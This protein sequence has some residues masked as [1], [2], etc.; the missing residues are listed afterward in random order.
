MRS[1]SQTVGS[2]LRQ[3]AVLP[4]GKCLEGAP[5]FIRVLHV[6]AC[7]GAIAIAGNGATTVRSETGFFVGRHPRSAHQLSAQRRGAP[8]GRRRLERRSVSSRCQRPLQGRN[9]IDRLFEE[10]GACGGRIFFASGVAWTHAGR[11]LAWHRHDYKSCERCSSRASS[12][13]LFSR[14][15][16]SAVA[17]FFSPLSGSG[18]SGS[19]GPCYQLWHAASEPCQCAHLHLPT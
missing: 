10:V 6:Y 11:R 15:D 2:A 9:P 19:S 5:R 17:C 13:H 1:D 3:R 8:S 16:Y 14:S 4:R 12:P 7:L 18:Y